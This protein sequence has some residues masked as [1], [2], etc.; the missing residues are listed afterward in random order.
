M[1]KTEGVP[2]ELLKIACHQV[3]DSIYGEVN[4]DNKN[5]Q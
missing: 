4:Y 5:Q 2:I 1:N 3:I